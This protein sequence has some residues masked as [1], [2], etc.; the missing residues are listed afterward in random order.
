MS[1]T[2]LLVVVVF[3]GISLLV[4]GYTSGSIDRSIEFQNQQIQDLQDQL[5]V[6]N[7]E[8]QTQFNVYKLRDGRL[9]AWLKAH[10]VPI[11]EIYNE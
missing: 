10:G 8:L 3:S 5:S 9:D 4:N 2:A 11:E 1:G 6:K 7:E